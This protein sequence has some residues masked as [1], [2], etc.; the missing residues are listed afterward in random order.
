M[1]IRDFFQNKLLER[2]LKNLPESERTMMKTLIEQ[3]PALFKEMEQEIQ[4][5][6]KKGQ[7]ETLASIAVMK[8]Y[9]PRIQELLIRQRKKITK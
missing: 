7:D 1:G 4:K 3:N 8:L 6:K 2:Q 9:S 5:R